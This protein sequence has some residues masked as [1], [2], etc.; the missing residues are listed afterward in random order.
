M[1]VAI[2]IVRLDPCCR[3][4][5]IRDIQIRQVACAEIVASDR[6]PER[7]AVGGSCHAD[8]L[9]ILS[10]R[11]ARH[12]GLQDL[13][14]NKEIR[15]VELCAVQICRL[16]GDNRPEVVDPSICRRIRIKRIGRNAD[17]LARVVAHAVAAVRDE[18]IEVFDEIILEFRRRSLQLE[19]DVKPSA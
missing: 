11:G 17:V 10:H 14:V 3:L 12:I 6:R 15:R 19:I 4:R 2:G 18:L 9:L 7:A 1:I 13:A 8:I 5:C 16:S